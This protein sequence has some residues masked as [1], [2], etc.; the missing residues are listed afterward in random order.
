MPFL[1]SMIAHSTSSPFL[2]SGHG[3]AFSRYCASLRPQYA[4]ASPMPSSGRVPPFDLKRMAASAVRTSSALS[5]S[6]MM[7]PACP[8]FSC[9]TM[10]AVADGRIGVN[11]RDLRDE[12]VRRHRPARRQHG[13]HVAHEAFG[14]RGR[15]VV[16]GEVAELV[17]HGF[18]RRIHERGQGAGVGGGAVA[19]RGGASAPRPAPAAGN[20]RR[21]SDAEHRQPLLVK[22]DHRVEPP[23]ARACPAGVATTARASMRAA[24][25]ERMGIL[26]CYSRVSLSS[27][28][29]S[30]PVARLGTSRTTTCSR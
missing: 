26:Q 8:A 4:A 5:T 2:L 27:G 15:V 14:V 11:D 24:D 9:S 6:C 30:E 20:D 10:R 25:P 18:A 1:L 19:P 16:V 3:S 21:V 23:L 7:M 22:G 13:R 29:I 12:R 17:R 28:M